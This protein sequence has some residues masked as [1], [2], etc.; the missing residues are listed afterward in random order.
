MID[1]LK[2]YFQAEHVGIWKG[3]HTETPNMLPYLVD[4][5]HH[6][7]VACKLHYLGVMKNLTITV[8]T[9]YAEFECGNV[10]LH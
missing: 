7:Y 5:G 8:P 9:V 6:D 4:A 10:A 1:I 2:R 3:H